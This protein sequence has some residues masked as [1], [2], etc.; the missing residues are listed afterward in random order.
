MMLKADAGDKHL[1]KVS[2]DRLLISILFADKGCCNGHKKEAHDR[3]TEIEPFQR[4]GK[5][6]GQQDYRDAGQGGCGQDF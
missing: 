4:S 2:P 6:Q 3:V 1:F 5:K